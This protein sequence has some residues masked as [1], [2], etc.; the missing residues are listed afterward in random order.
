MK[1]NHI[2][3]AVFLERPNR[4]IAY[5]EQAGKREICHVKN[6]GRCRELLLPGTQV[7]I[8]RQSN[9]ARKTPFDLIAVKKGERLIN[10]D[11][12]APNK[13]TAEW[14]RTSGFCALDAGQKVV[15]SGALF[16]CA[17]NA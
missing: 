3:Q 5:V 7:Y 12:Q 15:G 14:L 8:Q 1:Y 11:S 16:L 10:M 2:E 6:T 9:P 4:F 17:L 13:V